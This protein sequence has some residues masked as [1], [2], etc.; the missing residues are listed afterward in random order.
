M[1][2]KALYGVLS[3]ALELIVWFMA[4]MT[5]TKALAQRKSG[6]P[7]S[8]MMVC[9]LSKIFRLVLSVTPFCL[10]VCGTVNSSLIPLSAQYFS[11]E[12]LTYSP[13]QSEHRILACVP[14]WFTKS[15]SSLMDHSVKFDFS[16]HGQNHVYPDLSSTSVQK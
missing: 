4:Y 5:V 11:R 13:P 1:P 6:A 3:P 14:C 8:F 10:G 9:P 7:V 2:K 16:T 12:A 15:L